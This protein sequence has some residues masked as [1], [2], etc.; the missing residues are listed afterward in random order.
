MVYSEKYN[1]KIL[2]KI[3]EL[4]KK[5]VQVSKDIENLKKFIIKKYKSKKFETFNEKLDTI[6]DIDF[7]LT[8]N[9]DLN[10]NLYALQKYFNNCRV[11]NEELE[12]NYKLL[13]K[14]KICKGFNIDFV[15][16]SLNFRLMKMK[17]LKELYD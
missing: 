5:I 4:N 12:E 2:E 3:E 7:L 11:Y 10:N 1:N 15:D 17:N 13:D 14:L 6:K 9:S 16:A 8:E